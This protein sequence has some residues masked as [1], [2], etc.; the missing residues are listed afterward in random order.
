MRHPYLNCKNPSRSMVQDSINLYKIPKVR[1]V[2]NE[3]VSYL[4]LVNNVGTFNVIFNSSFGLPCK[5]S[6]LV[7]SKDTDVISYDDIEDAVYSV[8]DECYDSGSNGGIS[9]DYFAE[10]L[11]DSVYW[12]DINADTGELLNYGEGSFGINSKDRLYIC[13]FYNDCIEPI[14]RDYEGLPDDVGSFSEELF[15]KYSTPLSTVMNI[16][17]Y[18]RPSEDIIEDITYEK[19]IPEI[20]KKLKEKAYEVLIDSLQEN[21][22]FECQELGEYTF[23]EYVSDVSDGYDYDDEGNQIPVTSIFTIKIKNPKHSK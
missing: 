23:C 17:A 6:S 20:D 14:D 19:L 2:S 4:K 10:S 3:D 7:I 12:E 16:R 8:V 1:R 18:A 21:Y 11:I 9:L 22:R 13:A 15:K 5:F